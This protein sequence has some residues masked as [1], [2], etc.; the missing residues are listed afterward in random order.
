MSEVA[1]T[2]T[3][4]VTV[5]VPE[6]LLAIRITEYEPSAVKVWLGFWT[7][8]V[9]PSPKLHCQDVGV[10]VEESVKATAW[11]GAGEDGLKVNDASNAVA[12][13]IVTTRLVVLE[14]E[15]VA[16]VRLTV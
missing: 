7:V 8:L 9:P 1:A 6:A 4:R 15:P 2:E 12:G 13:A 10:P 5:S 3:V 11:L 14:P 16:A